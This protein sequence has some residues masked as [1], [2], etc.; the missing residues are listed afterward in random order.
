M[1][2]ATIDDEYSTLAWQKIYDKA[3]INIQGEANIKR[4]QTISSV[5]S[6]LR[7]VGMTIRTTVTLTSMVLIAAFIT[8]KTDAITLEQSQRFVEITFWIMLTISAGFFTVV[9]EGR[10]KN[11]AKS[12]AAEFADA[13][14]EKRDQMND[15]DSVIESRQELNAKQA[16]RNYGAPSHKHTQSSNA[17][18]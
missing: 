11:V 9:N 18:E 13:L 10:F 5:M 12:R 15:I 6:A 1:N 4:D 16:Y 7:L 14:I 3:L 17:G 8:L 2:T